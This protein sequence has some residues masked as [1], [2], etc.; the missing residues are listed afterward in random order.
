V[1]FT[2]NPQPAVVYP[3]LPHYFA[4][5]Y[6]ESDPVELET[7]TAGTGRVAFGVII[8]THSARVGGAVAITS[9]RHE[10]KAA[11]LQEVMSMLELEDEES[12]Q[13]N[14]AWVFSQDTAFDWRA[15]SWSEEIGEV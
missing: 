13:D 2:V 9:M 11:I 15:G 1:T 14:W 5:P 7:G 6:G 8:L 4:I 12:E 3:L 10:A